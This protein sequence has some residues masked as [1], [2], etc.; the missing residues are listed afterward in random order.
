MEQSI[1]KPVDLETHQMLMAY[2]DG[3]PVVEI[4]AAFGMSNPVSVYGRLS[5]FPADYADAKAARQAARIAKYRR[6]GALA[7]DL[8]LKYLEHLTETNDH[9]SL[10]KEVTKV[11]TIGEAAERRAD[12]NEGKPTDRTETLPPPALVIHMPGD[13]GD[14]NKDET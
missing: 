12:L 13:G 5:Q 3:T 9:K 1:D 2:A 14:D 6:A 8:Q 10:T 7:I 11:Q 4:A